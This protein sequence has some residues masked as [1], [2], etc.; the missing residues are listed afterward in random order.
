MK[1]FRL[2][3]WQGEPVLRD[4]PVPVPGPDEVLMQVSAADEECRP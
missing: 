4:G 3:S 1:A 2:E